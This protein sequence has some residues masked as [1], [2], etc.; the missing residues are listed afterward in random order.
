MK[1]YVK[2]LYYIGLLAESL[3]L[4]MV[5][6]SPSFPGE[7]PLFFSLIAFG[8]LSSLISGTL[9]TI[10]TKNPLYLLFSIGV[11]VWIALPKF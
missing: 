5:I 2:K 10:K 4:P 1:G 3:A 11:F 7:G 8:L 6:L 9:L